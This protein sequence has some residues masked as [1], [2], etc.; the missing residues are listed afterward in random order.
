MKL[1]FIGGGTIAKAIYKGLQKEHDIVVIK[2]NLEDEFWKGKVELKSP[3][4]EV[5]GDV[6]IIAVKPFVYKEALEPFIG[7]KG[8]FISVMAGIT[9]DMLK[10]YL[11]N[12][13]VV[14]CMPNLPVSVNEGYIPYSSTNDKAK[15]AFIEVFEPLGHLEA[16]E[17]EYL[18]ALT[19]L[20]GTSPLYI[21]VFIDALLDSGIKIGLPRELVKKAV[22]QCTMGGSKYLE[23]ENI[24]PMELK[25]M[26]SSPAGTS[27]HALHNLEKSGVKAAIIEAVEIAYNRSKK[28]QDLKEI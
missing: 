11:D 1:V 3:R 25:D 17:E 12:D 23:T 26:V 20:T 13:D 9:M 15:E 28:L 10:G 5:E 18:N 24:H 14:R 27:I 19:A 16:T 6:Y 2:R 8:V 21:S 4:S 7:K 22:V